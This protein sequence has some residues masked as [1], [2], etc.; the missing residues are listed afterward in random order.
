MVYRVTEA[1]WLRQLGEGPEARV[2]AHRFFAVRFSVV[3]GGAAEAYLP[4]FFVVDASGQAQGELADA[5]GLADWIGIVRKV[6]ANDTL[7]G[8]VVFDVEP[9]AY[10]LRIGE[11]GEQPAPRVELPLRF[12]YETGPI[13]ETPGQRMPGVQ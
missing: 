6:N 8:S 4:P 13:P 2:P 9:K 12:E 10:H 1:R 3:N 11:D 5:G 7:E